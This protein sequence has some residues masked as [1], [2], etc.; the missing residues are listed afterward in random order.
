MRI[1]LFTVASL[2]ASAA[3]LRNWPKLTYS[4]EQRDLTDKY[5]YKVTLEEFLKIRD[6]HA[7]QSK[8]FDWK[9]DGCSNV[10]ENPFGFDFHNACVRHDFGYHN[11]ILQRRCTEQERRALD[12]NFHKDMLHECHRKESKE[13]KL[14]CEIFAM[15]YFTAVKLLGMT[16]FCW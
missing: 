15:T 16:N 11:Y 7:L 13:R 9:S 4:F 1:S 14:E 6:Q 5:I 12:K 10:P 2:I 3:G 8:G